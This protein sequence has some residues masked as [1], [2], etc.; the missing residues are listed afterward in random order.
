MQWRSATTGADDAMRG[1]SDD[2]ISYATGW[3]ISGAG[4][5]G[6]HRRDLAAGDLILALLCATRLPPATSRSV[7]RRIRVQQFSSRYRRSHP[8][9]RSRY[10]V[11]PPNVCDPNWR[12]GFWLAEVTSSLECERRRSRRRGATGWGNCHGWSECNGGRSYRPQAS[13][14]AR[15]PGP[16][17]ASPGFVVTLL[18]PHGR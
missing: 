12:L 8:N 4:D 10:H 7:A 16:V 1:T 3:T 15:C 2:E 6:H 5:A 9:G 13:V 11:Y 14:R 17:V 18:D